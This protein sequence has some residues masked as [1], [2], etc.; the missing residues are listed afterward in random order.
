MMR[1]CSSDQANTHH[2]VIGAI[3]R[4]WNSSVSSKSEEQTELAGD[5]ALINPICTGGSGWSN[6]AMDA[7]YC[8]SDLS[9]VELS[10]SSSAHKK[11]IEAVQAAHFL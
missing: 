1:D 4:P 8:W 5:R 10:I 2:N 7:L 9:S 11:V 6:G 3:S